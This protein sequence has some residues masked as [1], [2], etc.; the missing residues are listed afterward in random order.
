MKSLGDGDE[1]ILGRVDRS[2]MA[3]RHVEAVRE[4]RELTGRIGLTCRHRDAAAER[5][6]LDG[7]RFDRAAGKHERAQRRDLV[8]RRRPGRTQRIR[9]QPADV[10]VRCQLPPAPAFA[11]LL[12]DRHDLAAQRLG[13]EQRHRA[14]AP[15]APAPVR[16]GNLTLNAIDKSRRRH[17]ASEM[18]SGK[19]RPRRRD[20]RIEARWSSAVALR[21][22]RVQRARRLAFAALRAGRAWR[23]GVQA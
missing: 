23:T 18:A 16:I 6:R 20:A 15:G 4:C 5:E 8:C 1:V 19:I 21:E 2:E 17:A 3:G 22:Q 10:A 14:P 11:V 9:R 13:I 7:R 12:V